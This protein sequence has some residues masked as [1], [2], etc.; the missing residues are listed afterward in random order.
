MPHFVIECS[1]NVVQHKSADQIMQAVYDTAEATGLF[2]ENDIKVRMH[3]FRYFQLAKNKKSFLH[4]FGYIMEGRTTEE[5]AGLSKAIVERLT[6]LLPF[7]SFI[8]MNVSDFEKAT[9]CNKS[10]IHPENETGDRH[11]LL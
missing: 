9:Y 5:K 4:V 1:E 3:P 7:V 2:A 6:I 11:F 8:A 10:I